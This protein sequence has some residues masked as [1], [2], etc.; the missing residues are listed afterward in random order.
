MDRVKQSN[1]ASGWLEDKAVMKSDRY[2]GNRRY[3][4]DPCFEWKADTHVYNI[5]NILFNIH[6]LFYLFYLPALAAC[7][8]ILQPAKK[9]SLGKAK[10]IVRFS[11]QGKP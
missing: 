11:C 7:E 3:H 9:C 6:Q 2:R 8:K 5:L 1:R 10:C 4:C